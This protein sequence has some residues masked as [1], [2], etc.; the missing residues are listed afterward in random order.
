M[1]RPETKTARR[2][3]I[4]GFIGSSDL[5]N[6]ILGLVVSQCYERSE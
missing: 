4:A 2:G 3:S 6:D 5:V 1:L